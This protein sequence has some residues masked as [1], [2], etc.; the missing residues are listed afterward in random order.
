MKRLA[1][2]PKARARLRVDGRET[3]VR[4]NNTLVVDREK[5]ILRLDVAVR[6]ALLVTVYQGVEYLQERRANAVR[7]RPKRASGN[8]AE[9]RAALA[10]LEY[11]THDTVRWLH[12]CADELE[13]ARVSMLR[14]NGMCSDLQEC[15]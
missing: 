14:C 7:I 5:Y 8:R 12:E 11:D 10:V 9:K 3:E 2:C 15:G 1:A 6:N 13:D 4:E